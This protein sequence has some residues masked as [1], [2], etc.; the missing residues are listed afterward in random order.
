MTEQQ[1]QIQGHTRERTLPSG[2]VVHET[3]KPYQTRRAAAQEQHK[4]ETVSTAE[5]EQ[6]RPEV[7]PISYEEREREAPTIDEEDLIRPGKPLYPYFENQRNI[8]NVADTYN[9]YLRKFS[10][11]L[12]S[13]VNTNRNYEYQNGHA[14]TRDF[15][16]ANHKTYKSKTGHNVNVGSSLIFNI[17]DR[18]YGLSDK[19]L[20]KFGTKDPEARDQVRH[21]FSQYYNNQ[22]ALSK[23]INIDEVSNII[24]DVLEEIPS[25][26]KYHM[27]IE[28]LPDVLEDPDFSFALP[29]TKFDEGRVLYAKAYNDIGG[30]SK[31]KYV[32][33][34]INTKDVDN[35]RE[36]VE[37]NVSK[38]NVNSSAKDFLR[39]SMIYK[40]GDEVK[41]KDGNGVVTS[42]GLLSPNQFAKMIQTLLKYE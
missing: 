30:V 23:S 32:V 21:F 38:L 3:V 6:E 7:A 35:I 5:P 24:E 26:S 15:L 22:H 33:A 29:Q 10:G 9:D 37:E 2:Q 17:L 20:S 42:V 16:K 28:M 41:A 8:T 31:G 12:R 39:V 25:D 1:V 14:N 19:V 13:P 40:R 11:R 4:P 36:A 18:E 34:I 27:A